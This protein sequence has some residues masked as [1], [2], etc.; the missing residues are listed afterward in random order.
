MKLANLYLK[1]TGHLIQ[2]M[3]RPIN[4]NGKTDK[5][6]GNQSTM[7]FW[8]H[9]DE[10]RSVIIRIVAT[11][12]VCTVALFAFMTDIFDKIILAPCQ[13]DFPLYR[14]FQSATAFSDV[15]PQLSNDDFSVELININLASQ[16]FIHISTSFWLALLL[17]TPFIIYYLW[18]FIS[19]GLYPNER[20][21]TKLAF[22]LGNFM[23]YL[24]VFVG[25]FIVFPVTLHFLAEYQVS[26]YIPNQISLDSYM[27]NFLGI[28]FVIGLT[29][30]LPLLC[31]LLGKIGLL[32]KQFFSKF[33][34]HAV[35]ALLVAAAFITPTGDPFTLA[36]VFAPLYILW[37]IS[38]L[39][40]PNKSDSILNPATN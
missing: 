21:S 34:R 37:E 35:V 40:V 5:L 33:R 14:I 3:P 25:Y 36:V 23:F 15:L 26:S 13:S 27:D 17:S 32:D 16:F 2:T 8:E 11:I 20:R 6:T 19:P 10:L 29:F 31:W 1:V 9:A 39:I 38:A 22:I 18:T 24:G 30:E 12:A 28:V 7:G 4:R